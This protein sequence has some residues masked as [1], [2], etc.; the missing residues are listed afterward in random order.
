MECIRSRL[1]SEK[2]IQL[3]ES[4]CDVDFGTAL[5]I[6]HLYSNWL[7]VNSLRDLKKK[8][9]SKKILLSNLGYLIPRY[10]FNTFKHTMI[11]LYNT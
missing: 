11:Y 1:G 7:S 9:R 2:K 4:E 10:N 8:S 6:I 3:S 5:G